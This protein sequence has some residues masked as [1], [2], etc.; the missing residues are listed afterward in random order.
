MDFIKW[1]YLFELTIL[2]I[3]L[4]LKSKKNIFFISDDAVSR[5]SASVM[6]YDL[7]KSINT[8][9]YNC[10]LVAPSNEIEK[11]ILKSKIKDVDIIFFKNGKI[12]NTNY[13]RRTINEL[14]LSYNL[15]SISNS[16]NDYKPV[17]IIYYSPSIFF[18]YA[19]KI[20][21]KRMNIKSYLI[22]RDIFPKWAVDLSIIKKNSIVHKF[23]E[24]FENL[25]YLAADR[26]GVM[27]KSNL[28]LFENRKDYNKF[29]ILY[30]WISTGAIKIEADE[31][32]LNSKKLRDKT[33]FFYGG[34]FGKAQNISILLNVIYKFKSNK[35]CY[36]VFFGD[37][38]DLS[39]VKEFS[40]KQENFDYLGNLDQSTYY[41]IA[42]T[43]DIGLVS[44]H[45]DHKTSNFPG[46]VFGYFLLSKAVV[47][48]FNNNNDFTDL[49]NNSLS[50]LITEYSGNEE[51]FLYNYI[52]M[53]VD[54]P[55]LVKK[56]GLKGN[57][58]L[59]DK[60]STAS[61]RDQ[62]IKSFD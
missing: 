13:Y 2:K 43:F 10:I 45:E 5:K 15:L 6:I 49:I 3:N 19:I 29:E 33:V 48:I 21:K 59:K 57:R 53:L 39:L 60:F 42:S 12:K 35:N 22:L 54:N 47:G 31:S 46:K 14:L 7:A 16:L 17:A 1:S 9:N 44:L 8:I 30:N 28:L 24:F 58:L 20:L 27:S 23:F 11:P 50:G 56:M 55:D 36:F 51:D 61:I 34:N 37:G 32:Y 52:T 41:S 38:D 62:I 18:G 26:I 40:D 25:N 4:D